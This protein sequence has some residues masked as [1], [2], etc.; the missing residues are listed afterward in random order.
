MTC[1]IQEIP[2]A[3]HEHVDRT[4]IVDFL[5]IN[6]SQFVVF[7]FLTQFMITFCIEVKTYHHRKFSDKLLERIYLK[8]ENNCKGKISLLCITSTIYELEK[9]VYIKTILLFG[10]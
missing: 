5:N 8:K 9:Y 2:N 10:C 3:Y 7:F 4:N 6:K 1:K